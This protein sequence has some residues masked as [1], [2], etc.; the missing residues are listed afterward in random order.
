MGQRV[1]IFAGFIAAL[2]IAGGLTAAGWFVGQGIVENR[3]ADRFVTVK[4]LAE[5]DVTADLAVWPITIVASGD[6]LEATQSEIE[7]D[8][9]ALTAF[10][11]DAG[12]DAGE[13]ALGRIQV[14]DRVAMGYYDPNRAQA[15]YLIRQPLRVRSDKVELVE[16]MS[17]RLGDVVRQGV[18]MQDWQGPSYIF[19]RLND[20][21]PE[22]L[23]E[24]TANAR[25][26]AQ[27]FADDS[28]AELAGI[29]TANQGVFVIL[30]RDRVAGASESDQV[31]KTVR[32]V[33]TITYALN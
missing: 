15:R 8:I 22:M 30:P 11:V 10:L 1:G 32:V 2:L 5:R 25:D 13:I 23:A 9:G 17:R 27:Q 7:T 33:A 12:F 21:K 31:D 3:T 24:A 4:G 18:V 19:S 14:E 26:A 16:R 28:G 29:R 20:I 6:G